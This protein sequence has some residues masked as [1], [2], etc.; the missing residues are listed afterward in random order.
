MTDVTCD[1]KGKYGNKKWKMIL[2][3]GAQKGDGTP[4]ISGKE[5]KE[6]TAGL[7]VEWIGQD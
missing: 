2:A 1:V 5:Q 7:I 4:E 6:I 3:Y